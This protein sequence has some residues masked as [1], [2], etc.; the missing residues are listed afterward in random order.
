MPPQIRFCVI[1]MASQH[2][3]RLTRLRNE[4]EL[5]GRLGMIVTDLV[6][7]RYLTGFTGSN[8]LLLVPVAE[9]AVF[10]TDGRYRDQ[11][12]AEV[13][14]ENQEIARDLIGSAAECELTGWVAETH[15]LDVD[16]WQRLNQPAPAG[17]LVEQLRVIKDDPEQ[18]LLAQACQISVAALDQLLSERIVGATEHQIAT[19]L[20]RIMREL[21][22]DDRAFETIVAAGE[23]SAIPHHR[24]TDREVG[25]GD[26]LKID[27]GAKVGGYH[28]DMTRTFVV[29]PAADWQ[30]E[31]HAAVREAQAVGVD[32]L[33]VGSQICSIDALVRWKL[34]ESGWLAHFTTGLGHGV[35]LQI[36][37][38]PFF[39]AK[40]TGKLDCCTV[41][42]MEPGIYLPGRGGVRIED[43]VRVTESEPDVL[44]RFTTELMEIT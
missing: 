30:R 39:S 35:G 25:K 2:S 10:L 14:L 19:R 6:N 20:E 33:R 21:G 4:I 17:R 37:E 36:H 28:A 3:A 26:L 18:Q 44:S 9:P 12:R 22:A 41:L 32:A 11:A 13:Q 5:A 31:I 40:D 15:L 42:T 27:F 24:A 16:S 29:G 1:E 7:I 34:D 23:N 8:A 38:D 43:T